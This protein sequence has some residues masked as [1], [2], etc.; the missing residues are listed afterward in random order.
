MSLI[1]FITD[2]GYVAIFFGSMFEGETIIVLGGFAAHEGLLNM[3]LIIPAAFLGALAGDWSFFFLGRKYGQKI[4]NKFPKLS[5]YLK[6]S[7]SMIDENTKK[8]SF[9]LRF[10]YGFRSIIPFSLGQSS[11]KTKDFLIYNT[12]GAAAWVLIMGVFG[13]LA[14]EAMEAFIGGIKKNEFKIIIFTVVVITLINLFT[15]S[16]K[17]LLRK[18][19]GCD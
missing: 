17:Y 14:G 11:I 7:L 4:M 10:M 6:K 18:K 9:S 5:C 2:Y 3:Y 1:N 12:I 19:K 16:F 13:Y 15:R 8:L